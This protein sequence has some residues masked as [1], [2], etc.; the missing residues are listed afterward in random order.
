MLASSKIGSNFAALKTKNGPLAQLN[1]AFDYGSKGYRFESCRDH[2]YKSQVL[3]NEALATFILPFCPTFAP[4]NYKGN[5]KNKIRNKAF[6]WF[7]STGRSFYIFTLIL[8]HFLVR[9]C[10]PKTL[11]GK[12]NH[13]LTKVNS[14]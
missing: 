8:H 7:N 12:D 14:Y 11:F 2:F 6:L 1:R 13:V 10:S 9:A 3:E 5:A 4:P